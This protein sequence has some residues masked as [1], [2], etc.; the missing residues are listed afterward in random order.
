MDFT[1]MKFFKE[2]TSCSKDWNYTLSEMTEYVVS[3]F[4]ESFNWILKLLNNKNLHKLKYFLATKV[5]SIILVSFVQTKY[6]K[7]K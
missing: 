7:E 4:I 2:H 6:I 1:L 3:P 5:L